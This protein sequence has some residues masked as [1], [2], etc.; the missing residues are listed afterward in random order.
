MLAPRRSGVQRPRC[1][2]V[3]AREIRFRARMCGPAP[4]AS[5]VVSAAAEPTG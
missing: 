3:R 2:G 1:E 4:R 5:P